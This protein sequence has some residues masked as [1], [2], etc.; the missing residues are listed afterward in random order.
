VTEFWGYPVIP[1][2]DPS[3]TALPDGPG[4]YFL[5]DGD[6]VVYVGLA[7]SIAARLRLGAHHVMKPSYR[8]SW[9]TVEPEDMAYAECFYIGILRPKRNFATSKEHADERRSW[10]TE[11]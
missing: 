5:W 6:E 8:V 7:L 1:S 4:I 10:K 2:P 11:E 3:T 9:V